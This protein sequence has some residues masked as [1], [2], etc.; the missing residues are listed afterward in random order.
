M[1]TRSILWRLKTLAQGCPNFLPT[2]LDEVTDDFGSLVSGYFVWPSAEYF[3]SSRGVKC[4][5]NALLAVHN[6]L[7]KMHRT[8]I[9]TIEIS[10]R[11]ASFQLAPMEHTARWL[12]GRT[13][14]PC[15]GS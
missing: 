1:Q 10:R 3:K 15:P 9:E 7:R 14:P 4:G 13:S 12:H 6:D 11:F 2:R 5:P 8:A